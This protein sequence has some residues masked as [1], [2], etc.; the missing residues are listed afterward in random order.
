MGTA[1]D[2]SVHIF[3]IAQAFDIF[4]RTFFPTYKIGKELRF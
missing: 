4:L 3:C 1:L 2:H